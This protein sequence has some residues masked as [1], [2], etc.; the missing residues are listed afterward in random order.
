M[1]YVVI[2][3]MLNII[4]GE[5]KKFVL[6]KPNVVLNVTSC[7]HIYSFPLHAA[8]CYQDQT[9]VEIGEQGNAEI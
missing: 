6:Q 1:F 9:K 4:S 5:D 3:V 2:K 8:H 7:H